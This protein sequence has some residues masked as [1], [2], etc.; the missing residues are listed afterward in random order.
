[1]SELG[2]DIGTNF[3]VDELVSNQRITSLIGNKT[4]LSTSTLPLPSI[5]FTTRE[6]NVV[7]KTAEHNIHVYYPHNN[8]VQ[9]LTRNG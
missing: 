7:S 5:A 3:T 1:M 2:T 4:M 8:R 6:F 9:Q